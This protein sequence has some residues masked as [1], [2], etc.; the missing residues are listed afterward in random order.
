M[1]K[2]YDKLWNI[3]PTVW[4]ALWLLIITLGSVT[5]LLVIVKWLMQVLGVM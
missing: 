3:I 2:F 1:K 5:L 4:G